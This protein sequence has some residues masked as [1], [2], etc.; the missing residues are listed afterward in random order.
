MCDKDS[1]QVQLHNLENEKSTDEIVKFDTG[2]IQDMFVALISSRTLV[3]SHRHGPGTQT[4]SKPAL[5]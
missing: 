4:H 5:D 2:N 3:M 1:L